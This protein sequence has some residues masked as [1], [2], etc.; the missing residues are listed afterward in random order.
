LDIN[1]DETKMVA[2]GLFG[3]DGQNNY[4]ELYDLKAMGNSPKKLTGFVNGV[5]DAHFTPD[6]K[7]LY[8]RDNGGRSIKYSDFS[9]TTQVVTSSKIN[10]LDL[11]GDGK[12]LAGAGDNGILYVWDIINNYSVTEIKLGKTPLSAVTWHPTQNQLVV[13]D[14]NG[15][16]RIIQGEMVVRTL[17]GHRGPIEEIKYNHAANF[18]ASASKDRTVRLWDV[19][20]LSV[21]PIQLRDHLD[22]V[23]A[24]SFSPDDEQIMVGLHSSQQQVRKDEIRTEQSIHA[25][26]TK[27]PTMANILCTQFIKQNMTKEE[28]EIYVGEDLDYESTCKSYPANNN[29]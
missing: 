4:I 7:G 22:W 2:A 19:S 23:W 14:D 8:V 28:W 16:I 13:G 24:L 15:L 29:K 26:P 27:I 3:A 17:S 6:G 10:S 21:P 12:K 11:S 5:E 9:K 1:A 25:Y 18:F 20:K